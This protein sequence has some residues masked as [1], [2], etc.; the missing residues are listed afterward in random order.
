MEIWIFLNPIIKFIYYIASLGSIGTGLFIAHFYHNLSLEQKKFCNKTLNKFSILGIFISLI[1]LISIPANLSGNV[2]GIFDI[3]LIII[4][5]ESLLAKSILFS[6]S[7]FT[8]ILL[9][10]KSNKFFFKMMQLFGFALIFL[11]FVTVGHS[12]KNGLITQALVLLHIIGISF[13]IG[14]FIPLSYLCNLDNLKELK[15]I[16]NRFST[17]AI[18]YVFL[19]I[20]AGIVYSIILLGNI[21]SLFFT[22]YGNILCFKIIIVS[23]LLLIGALNKLFFVPKL[24]SDCEDSIKKL[25]KS[26]QVEK[27]LALLILS[28]TT[29]LTTS[30]NLPF[31]N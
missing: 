6:F 9:S 12:L 15:I 7:G 18:G 3:D 27:I 14:S 16:A 28:F 29:I 20:T 30:V 2:I 25:K 24:K 13:W 5:I 21:S 11:S 31:I 1:F 23:C 8:L 17:Y 4:S 22:T 10:I 26:I 19:L